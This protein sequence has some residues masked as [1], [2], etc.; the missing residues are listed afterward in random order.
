MN[1]NIFLLVDGLSPT[2]MVFSCV[3]NYNSFHKGMKKCLMLILSMVKSIH[4]TCF[5]KNEYFSHNSFCFQFH[6]VLILFQVV[7][8]CTCGEN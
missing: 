4:P 3:L 8:S 1:M 6:L 5:T 2:S 7:G